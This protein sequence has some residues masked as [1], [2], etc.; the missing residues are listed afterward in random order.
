VP[1]DKSGK[2]VKNKFYECK[3]VD[4]VI[5]DSLGNGVIDVNIEREQGTGKVR[6]YRKAT[7]PPALVECNVS[8]CTFTEIE[9]KSGYTYAYSCETT[10]C[11]CPSFEGGACKK[12]A[13]DLV[14]LIK[15]RSNVRCDS[16]TSPLKCVFDQQAIGFVINVVCD[17]GEC[18][19]APDTVSQ[20]AA[21]AGQ[22][23]AIFLAIIVLMTLP[24]LIWLI[25][26]RWTKTGRPLEHRKGAHVLFEDLSYEIDLSKSLTY[27]PAFLI[28]EKHRERKKLVV[29]DHVYGQVFPGELCC[30]LGESGSGKTSLLDILAGMDKSGRVR[31]DIAIDG[32]PRPRDF[33]FQAGYVQQNDA[34]LGTLTV[35]EQL[36][37]S[38]ELR[39]P[40]GVSRGDK[41]ALVEDTMRE[42]GLIN[43]RHTFIGSSEKRG[44]SGGEKRRVSIATE[45]VSQPRVLFLDEPTSGLDSAR[46]LSVMKLLKALTQDHS[47]TVICSIHQPRSNIFQ[48][49]DRVILLSQGRV[50][51]SGPRG[52]VMN[53]FKRNGYTCPKGFNHADFLIDT[54]TMDNKD[55]IDV[56]VDAARE[57]YRATP[58]HKITSADDEASLDSD[59]ENEP[60]AAD[61]DKKKS[62]K[63]KKRSSSSKE[64]KNGKHKTEM[65]ATNVDEAEKGTMLTA[66][67][68]P[69]VENVDALV[70]YKAARSQR[71][72]WGVQVA[73]L[74]HRAFLNL[75]RNPVLLKTHF[76]ATVII[77]IFLGLAYFQLT[78]NI[79]G[80]QNRAGS[81]FFVLTMLA[82]SCLSALDLCAS[83][84]LLLLRSTLLTF[85]QLSASGPSSFA[86]APMAAIKWALTLSARSSPICC[87]CASCCRRSL[88]R[89]CSGW[90]STV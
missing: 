59:N 81:L 71:P 51:F 18:A 13:S 36:M 84:L 16:T 42:L 62:G 43:R 55:K 22:I 39:L 14:G 3:A 63:K 27:V 73:L 21:I 69:S 49:F 65:Q 80:F 11:S 77:A 88:R 70:E 64:R 8:D 10:V 4:Q 15:G 67:E 19:R 20:T 68:S 89:S 54:V 1:C 45:L 53:F 17:P 5:I 24:A 48:L 57:Y 2:P 60:L 31:G 32:R 30:I 44:I 78:D 74:T 52:H 75:W 76:I 85:L 58:Q 23:A 12:D 66:A 72:G 83:P 82:F 37:Y 50:V 7:G 56:L 25:Y 34:M 35:Q 79:S 29:L 9:Q 61:L 28:P 26:K 90:R 40:M 38:A 86:S 33:K 46:A 6:I 87:L 47:Q 41:E